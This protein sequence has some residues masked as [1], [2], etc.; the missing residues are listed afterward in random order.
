MVL[1]NKKITCNMNNSCMPG[2]VTKMDK[3]YTQNYNNKNF[4]SSSSSITY[5]PTTSTSP[6]SGSNSIKKRI[7]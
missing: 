6:Q 7:C 4:S 1:S 5:I 2:F 3:S